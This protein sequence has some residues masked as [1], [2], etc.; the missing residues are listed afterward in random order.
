MNKK[1]SIYIYHN[2]NEF[3]Q[4]MEFL[5]DEY[6]NIMHYHKYVQDIVDVRSQLNYLQKTNLLCFQGFLNQKQFKITIQDKNDKICITYK[7]KSEYDYRQFNN[8]LKILQMNQ[9]TP[10]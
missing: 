10:H 1:T 3:L 5:A 4:D 7:F 8:A 9:H 2:I 6:T